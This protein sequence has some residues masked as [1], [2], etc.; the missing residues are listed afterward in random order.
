MNYQR[1]AK[2]DTEVLFRAWAWRYGHVHLTRGQVEEIGEPLFEFRTKQ[3]CITRAKS[4]T[5]REENAKVMLK[6]PQLSKV[7]SPQNYPN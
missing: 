3:L 6:C 5:P 1:N 7:P 2:E 4:S